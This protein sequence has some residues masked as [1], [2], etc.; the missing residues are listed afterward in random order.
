MSNC[1]RYQ[2][3]IEHFLADEI[4]AEDRAD[5][6]DHCVACPECTGLMTLHQD[7]LALGREIPLP[8]RHD[9]REMREAVLAV[10]ATR[11]QAPGGSG[12]PAPKPGFLPDLGRFWR[13]HPVPSGLAT[14]AVLVCAVFLG[15]WSP[16]KSSFVE[17]LL[18]QSVQESKVRQGGLDGYWEAPYSFANVSVRPQGQGILALSFDAS[19]HVNLQVAQDSPLAKEVLLNAILEPSSMGSQLRAMEV[20]P[21]IRDGRLKDALIVTMLNDPDPTVRL[22]ALN[23]LARYPY[24]QQSQ[25]ALLQTLG[26]DKDV[27]MRLTALDELARR[28]V[29]QDTI[30][31]AVGENA[32]PGTMAMLRQA[33]VSF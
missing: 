33:A 29:G 22:N 24:D 18:R 4:S 13:A 32:P 19:R 30:R 1:R 25:D 15:Q 20:T 31:H 26:Q 10:T 7:L 14:A 21:P 17:E 5:L 2:E 16:Q 23:V 28:N 9:L 3:L 27:Q 8:A 12:S 6:E 11:Q